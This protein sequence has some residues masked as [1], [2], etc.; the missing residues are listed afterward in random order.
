MSYHVRPEA[1][2]PE[3]RPRRFNGDKGR[4][5]LEVVE[6]QFREIADAQTVGPGSIH[7]TQS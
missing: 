6:T 5:E 7:G 4:L 3:R 1:D 2:V